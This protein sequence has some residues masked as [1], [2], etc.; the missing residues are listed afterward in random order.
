MHVKIHDSSSDLCS[1]I[2]STLPFGSSPEIGLEILLFGLFHMLSLTELHKN[3]VFRTVFL[4]TQCPN[5][6]HLFSSSFPVFENFGVY[7]SG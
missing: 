2:C 4:Q 7:F 1:V 6:L 5:N 3:N